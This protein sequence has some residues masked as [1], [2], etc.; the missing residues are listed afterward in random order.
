MAETTQTTAPA[1]ATPTGA[2]AGK[3][4]G[5]DVDQQLS[6]FLIDPEAAETEFLP[7]E[8]P[9]P[10]TG[11]EEVPE[12]EAKAEGE[13]K[14]EE[15][16]PAEEAPPT[17]TVKV[18]GTEYDVDEAELIRG[19]QLGV[20]AQQKFQEAASMRGEVERVLQTLVADP[21]KILLNPELE[22]RGFNFRKIAEE[23]LIEQLKMETA[24]PATK[25]Q[26]M[27]EQRVK[28][29]EAERE[30]LRR[31][32]EE[33]EVQRQTAEIAKQI[34]ADWTRA[35]TTGK[36]P[37][38][39]TVVRRMA[40]LASQFLDQGVEPTAEQLVDIVR[41]EIIQSQ[42]EMTAGM[43]PEQLQEVVGKEKLDEVRKARVAASKKPTAAQQVK[44]FRPPPA[45]G[46]KK[47]VSE[48]EL[49]EHMKKQGLKGY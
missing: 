23:F 38:T 10:V 35:L 31:Q 22:R 14:P 34:D 28:Q 27:A 7:G 41:Q 39:P 11:A 48:R 24:D 36:V 18:N 45:T 19:Y 8:D 47:Y 26:L 42:R 32:N 4:D 25:A 20:G 5:A 2:D 1:A 46:P 17:W 30:A 3:Q 6:A 21:L 40:D 49:R 44:Q 29:L 43:T 13:E 9:E 16:K 15:E 12:A 37:K 33:I